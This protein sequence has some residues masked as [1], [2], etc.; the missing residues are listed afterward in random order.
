[1]WWWVG[2][3]RGVG[4]SGSTGKPPVGTYP[5][6]LAGGAGLLGAEPTFHLFHRTQKQL[7]RKEKAK[8]S[9]QRVPLLQGE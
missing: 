2:G 8:G 3:P 4:S 5:Q 1:M 9:K 7:S 6:T